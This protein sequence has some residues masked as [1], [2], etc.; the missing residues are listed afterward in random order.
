MKNTEITKQ[1]SE[2]VFQLKYDI[3]PQ[4]VRDKLADFII[5]YYSACYAGIKI[6]SDFNLI[7]GS[8]IREN[9]GKDE[10]SV[11]FGSE[12]TEKLPAEN[13]AFLNAAYAHGADMDDGNRKAMGHIGSHVISSVFALAESLTA[14]NFNNTITGKAVLEAVLVG[15]EVFARVAYA[16]QPGLVHRGF[17]STS[18]AGGIACAAACAKLLKLSQNGIYNAMSLAAVQ[19]S[20]LLLIAESGQA[21]KPLNPAN[22]AR[23]GIF[24]AKL[25]QKGIK[26]PLVPLE[27]DK[28]WLHA[29]TD[30]PHPER[31]TANF[32]ESYAICE[33]YIKP[34]PSCRHTHC[35]IQGALALRKMI[36]EKNGVFPVANIEKLNVYIYPNAI[37]VAGQIKIPRT[38]EDT[39]FSIHYAMAKALEC[40]SFDIHSLDVK[41]ISDTTLD[42]IS[43]IEC[44]PDPNMERID[45]GIRGAKTELIMK[46]GDIYTEIVNIP[47]GDP[48]D[49]MSEHELKEKLA[50]CSEGLLTD[51]QREALVEN[52]R[53]LDTKCFVSIN[54]LLR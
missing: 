18:T 10:A 24:S 51:I 9:C 47:K 1:L 13:A 23:I 4:K 17:H 28:G 44:I 40:G 49:P 22:A 54:E 27:S 43:K 34:Y 20:G 7:L 42:L 26:A 14:P 31:I 21:C 3:L 19:S 11:L 50:I 39:K 33:S 48:T 46:N 29:M 37:N 6:N 12:I 30:E 8:I 32:F 15:Y 16:A 2:F 25:A 41:L 38:S 35:V 53:S 45:D 36:S 52:V 5:D